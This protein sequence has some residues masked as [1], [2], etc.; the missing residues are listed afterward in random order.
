MNHLSDFL[1]Y[2]FKIKKYSKNTVDAYRTDLDQFL[3]FL[4]KELINS[5]IDFNKISKK[6]IKSYI[7][8]LSEM[9]LSEKSI[10]R[11]LASIKSFFRF[12]YKKKIS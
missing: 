6:E 4:K 9:K 2:I 3:D 8:F 7:L 10:N 11:K 1:I 12:L 5:K